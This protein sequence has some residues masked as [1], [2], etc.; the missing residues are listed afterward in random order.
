MSDVTSFIA[1]APA[2]VR[3]RLRA[4]RAAIRSAV[5]SAEECISYGMPAYRLHGKVFFGF[6]HNKHHVGIYPWSGSFLTAHKKALAG[7]TMT[8]GALHLPH[9]RPLPL[10]LLKKLV[11]ARA[12]M[13]RPRR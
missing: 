3:P 5:P 7:F 2:A 11:R 4:V 10:T 8:A 1:A 13:V 9:D 6:R 12:N